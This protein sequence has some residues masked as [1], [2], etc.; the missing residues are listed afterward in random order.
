VGV[1]TKVDMRVAL[2]STVAPGAHSSMGI[3]GELVASAL[4]AHAPQIDAAPVFLQPSASPPSGRLGERWALLK[5]IVRSRAASGKLQADVFHVLDGSFGYMATGLPLQRTLVTVHDLIPAWQARGRFPVPKPGWAAQRLIGSS[6]DLIRRARAVH[7]VSACTADDIHELTGRRVDA[8]IP[9][10]VRSLTRVRDQATDKS[11]GVLHV[12]NNGFYKNRAG[13][14]EI[15]AAI[16]KR[17]PSLPLVMAGPEPTPALLLRAQDLG[18]TGRVRWVAGPSD[19]DLATLYAQARLLLF[20]SWYEGFGWPPLEAMQH[21]CPVVCAD[22][23]SLPEVVGDAA[24]LWSPQDIEGFA[25]Q[26]LRV[27]DDEALQRALI[28]RG[29]RRVEAFSLQRLAEGLVPLYERLAAA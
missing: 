16:A 3:F 12:G 1:A 10:P 18:L 21:G 8:V 24:L 17:H 23:G 6:L 25:A 27:L 2:I 4:R 19:D 20:P 9:N 26:A 28:V 15:F 13:V 11:A 29:R 7:A 14:L 22:T 5:S